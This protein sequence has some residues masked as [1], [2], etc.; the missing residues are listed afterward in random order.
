[1][2][3][4]PFGGRDRRGFASLSPMCGYSKKTAAGEPER[5]PTSGP[6]YASALILDFWSTR[7][8]EIKSVVQASCPTVYGLLQQPE[9]TQASPKFAAFLG[10][11]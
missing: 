2:G 8:W 7:L 10:F 9:L 5:E 11:L 4:V 3:L 1:M 6:D